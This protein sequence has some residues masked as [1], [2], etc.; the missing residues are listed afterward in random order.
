MLLPRVHLTD[1][2]ARAREPSIVAAEIRRRST[3]FPNVSN[4]QLEFNARWDLMDSDTGECRPFVACIFDTL[5][6]SLPRLSSLTV[7][8]K[9]V[10]CNL[11][12]VTVITSLTSLDLGS[13]LHAPDDVSII[14]QRC[15]QLHTLRLQFPDWY[16]HARSRYEPR[17]IRALAAL[18]ELSSLIFG[19]I[20]RARP[21][22]ERHS[23]LPP[24]RSSPASRLFP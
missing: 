18:P 22:L 1:D 5:A 7:V 3:A 23:S 13:A 21:R 4:I 19:I 11:N 9:G 16:M 17:H 24:R 8:H 6:A 20:L 14:A 12:H 10:L 15:K 2:N